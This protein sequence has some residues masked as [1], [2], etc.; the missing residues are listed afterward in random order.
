M[1]KEKIIGIYCIENLINGKKYIGLSK[2]V[3]KR[4]TGHFNNANYTNNRYSNHKLYNSIRKYGKNNFTWYVL[5][6]CNIDTLEER[7]IYYILKFNSTDNKFGYNNESGGKANIVVHDDTRLKL[8][9]A[10]LRIPV[11]KMDRYGKFIKEYVSTKQAAKENGIIDRDIKSVISGKS[12]F[13][14]NWIFETSEKYYKQGYFIDK[15]NFVVC[16]DFSGN[17]IAEYFSIAEAERN[18]NCSQSAISI[19]CKNIKNGASGSVSS[20]GFLWVKYTDY[21]SNNYTINNPEKHKLKSLGWKY[22]II[23][24][25]ERHV[26]NQQKDII[27]NFGLSGWMIGKLVKESNEIGHEIVLL[28]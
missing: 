25:G 11:V 12:K 23:I 17:F 3:N 28:I 20:K 27:G 24:N 2:D 16:L 21:I 9:M 5:E 15:T 14:K 18:T 1:V 6:E 8:Q 10:Q 26:F 19:C 4:I 13:V 22:I 7:E